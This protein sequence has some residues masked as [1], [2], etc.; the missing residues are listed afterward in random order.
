[1]TDSVNSDINK[2]NQTHSSMGDALVQFVD[3]SFD[4]GDRKIFNGMTLEIPRGKLTAILGGSGTG[5]TTLLN[6]IGGRLKP[7]S[8]KVIVDGLSVP[9]LSTRELYRLR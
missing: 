4:R 7:S 5:K 2:N 1:M 8:G 6:I 9:D 3:V